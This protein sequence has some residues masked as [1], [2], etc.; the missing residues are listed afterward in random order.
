MGHTPHD[1]EAL[2]LQDSDVCIGR[3][4]S[5]K[6]RFRIAPDRVAALDELL[7]LVVDELN[8]S[9]FRVHT[10][11]PFCLW[12]VDR[13]APLLSCVSVFFRSFVHIVSKIFS[14]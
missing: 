4:S 13:K 11:T 7:L 10:T 12:Y 5:G 3:L 1:L 6:A 8:N 14:S 9:C 2:V